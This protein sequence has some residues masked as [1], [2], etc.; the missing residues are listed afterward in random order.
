[1][2]FHHSNFISSTKITDSCQRATCPHHHRMTQ[3]FQMHILHGGLF[4]WG[5]S[6]SGDERR[7]CTE[8]NAVFS[9]SAGLHWSL[10]ISKQIAPLWLLTLG[11]LGQ[12]Q[13]T[14]PPSLG[15]HASQNMHWMQ[16]LICLTHLRLR[17]AK[18]GRL[19]P[20]FGTRALSLK[21]TTCDDCL[22]E[23]LRPLCKK[24][25]KNGHF[26]Q[27]YSVEGCCERF[28]AIPSPAAL[29][30]IC[31]CSHTKPSIQLAD[32][33]G[34]PQDGSHTPV[35]WSPATLLPYRY[36]QEHVLRGFS[37]STSQRAILNKGRNS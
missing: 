18:A 37:V 8:S 11:C 35:L 33:A 25:L 19:I 4:T 24:S 23:I 10:R 14:P 1:M 30:C 26:I 31:Y 32:G 16:T 34:P 5:S 20:L 2:T 27:L 13:P 6:G 7:A 17:F 15:Q 12:T 21:Q 28:G 22:D 29:S 36:E 3:L 9:V